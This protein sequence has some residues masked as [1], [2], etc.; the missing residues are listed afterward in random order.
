[1]GKIST[2][3]DDIRKNIEGW[4]GSEVLD[5]KNKENVIGGKNNPIKPDWG[6]LCGDSIPA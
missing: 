3:L 5:D 1:M 6:T 2:S 4:V